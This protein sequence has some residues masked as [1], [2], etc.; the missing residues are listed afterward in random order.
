MDRP[1][2]KL[3]REFEQLKGME[4]EASAIYEKIIP[5]LDNEEYKKTLTR[6]KDDE[7]RHAKMA[8]SI[9]DLLSS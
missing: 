9:I 4:E 7:G 3:I 5:L 1:N 2:E 8:Q 6:I